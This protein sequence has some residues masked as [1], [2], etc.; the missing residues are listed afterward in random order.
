MFTISTTTLHAGVLSPVLLPNDAFRQ[1]LVAVEQ[2]LPPDQTCF[3]SDLPTAYSLARVV[4][5][6]SRKPYE[7]KTTI[8]FHV[9]VKCVFDKFVWIG[10]MKFICLNHLSY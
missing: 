3:S 2:Q 10:K 8:G 6:H 5:V 4:T 7:T 1:A 9:E